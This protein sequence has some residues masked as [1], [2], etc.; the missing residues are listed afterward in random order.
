MMGG[1]QRYEYYD[2]DTY[3]HGAGLFAND[4]GALVYLEDILTLLLGGRGCGICDV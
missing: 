1:I 2:G 3:G 4:E